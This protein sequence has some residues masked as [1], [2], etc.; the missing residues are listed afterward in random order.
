MSSNN[1]TEGRQ[2]ISA[3]ETLSTIARK[4]GVT[5]QA[6]LAANTQIKDPDRIKVGQ[7]INLPAGRIE[8]GAMPEPVPRPAPETGGTP[9]AALLSDA[10]AGMDKR[11][12]AKKVH[13]ILRERLAL[14]ALILDQR[15]M[16][17]LITDGLR[18]FKEQ[19]DIFKIGR[20]GIRGESIVTKARG[21]QSNHNYGLA[22][23]MY[24]VLPDASG[25]EKVFTDIPKNASVEFKRAFDR[26]QRTLGE[27]SEG[28]GLFWGARFS[29][30][31]DTPHVQL[32][33][34]R[35]MKPSECL[36]ILNKN[37][38]NLNAVWEEAARRAKP[39]P[40]A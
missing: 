32:L 16:K 27:E 4:H 19:D 8:I 25:R 17:A 33:S 7:I 20:R 5:L 18:T 40:G 23:D 1:P 2:T 10:F 11:G 14:L 29:G 13:P 21:G 15:G 35:E 38:G 26:I 36:R 30:I 39:L 24:P 37:D 12:K 6:L 34:E 3:G 31:A 9:A 28:L 22:V